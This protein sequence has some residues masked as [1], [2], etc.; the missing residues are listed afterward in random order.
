MVSAGPE[1]TIVADKPVEDHGTVITVDRTEDRAPETNTNANFCSAPNRSIPDNDPTG[2]VDTIIVPEGENILDLNVVITATHSWVGDLVFTLVHA[3]TG[4][5]VTLIDRPGYP[6]SSYGCSANNVNAT[7]DDEAYAWAE[8][9]CPPVGGS[10]IP[11]SPLSQF[12]GEGLSGTWN[13]RV[14][15]NVRG[16]TGRLTAW[17]LDAATGSAPTISVDAETLSSTQPADV[18]I[19]TTLTITNS[20]DHDLT[21]FIDE[22]NGAQ[23][24]PLS[25]PVRGTGT[26]VTPTDSAPTLSSDTTFKMPLVTSQQAA[27]QA[28][29]LLVNDGSFENSPTDWHLTSNGACQWI[30]NWYSAW[31]VPAYDGS[32]DYWSGGYCYNN[33]Y[34]PTTS[35]VTQTLTIPANA[36]YLGFKYLA[37]RPDVDDATPN[38]Y[39]YVAVDGTPL[40]T[41]DSIQANNTFPNWETAEVDISAFA[42]QEVTLTLGFVSNADGTADYTGNVRFDYVHILDQ[43]TCDFPGDISWLSVSPSSGV[44]AP[45]SSSIL[46]VTFDSTGLSDGEYSSVLCVNSSDP[47]TPLLQ[48]PVTLTVTADTCTAPAAV[49]NLIISQNN[50]NAALNWDDIPEADHYEVWWSFT[51]PYFTPG[52]DCSAATNCEVSNNPHYIH[53][54]GGLGDPQQN[55]TYVVRAVSE[56][57]S[58]QSDG[59][60]SNRAAEFDFSIQPGS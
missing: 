44:T 19:T 17:C 60:L 10:F 28:M 11:N 20:G 30:D 12:D 49:T 27:P 39:A 52:E 18:Q 51:D 3:E 24:A 16:D 40:W 43:T 46:D 23:A 8:N 29:Q 36:H 6:A 47:A 22:A 26:A 45:Q 15:D 38:D 37:Y 9:A 5:A 1:A 57:G 41:L 2:I 59:P 7:L 14:S 25:S 42:G 33:A 55:F 56:C 54:T 32:M 4:T 48:V 21:W 50:G 58:S 34:I 31:G 35:S 53:T 13:L